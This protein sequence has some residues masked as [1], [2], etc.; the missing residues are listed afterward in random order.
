MLE[1]GNNDVVTWTI[2]N[3][4]KSLCGTLSVRYIISTLSNGRFI[5]TKGR[6]SNG[7]FIKEKR[8]LHCRREDTISGTIG[9]VGPKFY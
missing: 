6:P 9:R 7:L 5:V 2:L 4:L 8:E 1:N 3:P